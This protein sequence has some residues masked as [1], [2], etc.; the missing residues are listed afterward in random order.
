MTHLFIAD[1]A[2]CSLAELLASA[3]FKVK[4]PDGSETTDYALTFPSVSFPL[5]SQGEAPGIGVS[6]WYFHPCETA[7]AVD[8]FLVEVAEASWSEEMRLVRWI[9]LWLMIV[10]SVL[11]V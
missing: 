7:A 3:F 8:E 11:N 10:G 2:L 5:L 6:C 9:E 1:G 4:P